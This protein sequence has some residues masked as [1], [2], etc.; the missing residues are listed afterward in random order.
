MASELQVTTLKGNPTGAN[1]N[2]ILVPAN[3]TLHAPGHVIQVVQGQAA[4]RVQ[5]SAFSYVTSNLSQAITPKVSGSKVLIRLSMPF[6]SLRNGNSF[7]NQFQPRILKDG[8]SHIDLIGGNSNVAYGYQSN[9][10]DNNQSHGLFDILSY[11]YLDTTTGTSAITYSVDF[12]C[13]IATTGYVIVN[14]TGNPI[15]SNLADVTST[16]TLMEIAQ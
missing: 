1:A 8:V 4:T 12:R 2:Q 10:D 5:S 15:N 6:T 3:Q 16:L 14:G 7:A 11:E 9:S 13:R